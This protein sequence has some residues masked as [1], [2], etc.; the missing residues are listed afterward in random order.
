MEER[1]LRISGPAPLWDE[2]LRSWLESYIGR[3]PHH[4]TEVLSRSQYIGVARAALD[5]YLAGIYFLPKESGGEGADPQASRIE[6][7]I[8][9]YR[10]RVE[11]SVRHGYANT[12]METRTWVQMQRACATAINENVIVVVYGT[13]GVGKS[14]CLAEFALQKMTTAPVS[15]LCSRNITPGYFAQK[16][17]GELDLDTRPTT[18]KLE[19]LIAQKLR[20][21]PRPI[22]IDQA[23]YLSERSLG[24]VCYIW[25]VARVPF[26]LVGSKDLYHLFTTSRLTEDVRAQ[27]SSRV[28][29][30]CQYG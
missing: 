22:F 8:R 6:G 11:G 7:T 27:I 20:R 21:D 3:Y 25:E 29:P 1:K 19:D 13:P 4:S 16:V 12:F 26:V 23:N 10:E 5:A 17:A 9:A 2:E 30:L 28:A 14:R 15:I 18:A 24:S